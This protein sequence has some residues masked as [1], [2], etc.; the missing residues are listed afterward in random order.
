MYQPNSSRRSL[1]GGEVIIACRLRFLGVDCATQRQAQ[2]KPS[3]P[4]IARTRVRWRSSANLFL[5]RCLYNYEGRRR[6]RQPGARMAKHEAEPPDEV[7]VVAA[8]LGDLDA[9]DEL[10]TRYR[11]A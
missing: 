9:F 5:R 2:H 10:A 4:T 11:T 8:I 7:L 6:W 3:P 1:T